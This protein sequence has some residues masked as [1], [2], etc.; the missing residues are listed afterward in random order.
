MGIAAFIALIYPGYY[1]VWAMKQEIIRFNY[2][3]NTLDAQQKESIRTSVLSLIGEYINSDGIDLLDPV[4]VNKYFPMIRFRI[5]DALKFSVD[6]SDSSFETMRITMPASFKLLL[7]T[8][9]SAD[10]KNL[11]ADVEEMWT[12]LYRGAILGN[13]VKTMRPVYRNL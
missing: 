2:F 13:G 4:H 10:F 6:N 12:S 11:R 8:L 7:Y 1:L 9:R 5:R 3:L